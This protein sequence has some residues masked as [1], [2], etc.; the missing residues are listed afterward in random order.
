MAWIGGS[1][2]VFRLHDSDDNCGSMVSLSDAAEVFDV[3]V[4]ALSKLANT[5][6][7]ITEVD[8]EKFVNELDLHK[9]WGSGAI[10]TAHLPKIGS[11]KRSLD[12][13]ILIKLV[14]LTYPAASIT[15][16]MKAGR[17]QVD[18]FV[19]LEAKRLAIEFFGPSHFIPQYPGELKLPNERRATIEAQLKC[20]CV[21]WPYWIQRC[22]SNV[23][24]IFDPVTEGKAS[25]WSTKAHFGDFV[26][27]NS[28]AIIIEL[29]ERFNAVGEDGLGYM[30]LA[31]RTKHKP[32]HPIVKRIM[33]GKQRREKLIPK[34]NDRPTSFWLP[35][36]I[37]RLSPKSQ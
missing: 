8:G 4:N 36:C 16:Q 7:K 23:R 10:P 19:E 32:V 3:S 33:D 14:K 22:A 1:E 37:E 5:T 15:P 9:A 35:Q 13:L 30:Y 11:A 29:S 21:V 26:F 17:Q 34:G 24:A 27:P 25:V 28:A 20:E 18:L 2:G 6:L 31:E 12:E